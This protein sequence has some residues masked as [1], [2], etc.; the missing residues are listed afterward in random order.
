VIGDDAADEGGPL[1]AVYRVIVVQC[2][3]ELAGFV[4]LASVDLN[5]VDLRASR[6]RKK[7][8]KDQCGSSGNPGRPYCHLEPPMAVPTG[9]SERLTTTS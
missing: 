7:Q 3:A 1:W 8:P 9:K 5:F 2:N 4:D 6:A